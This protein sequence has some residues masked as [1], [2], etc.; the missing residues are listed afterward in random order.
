MVLAKSLRSSAGMPRKKPIR[1]TW[2]SWRPMSALSGSRRIAV[3]F[4][5]AVSSI[6]TPPS[7]DAMTVI[8]FVARSRMSP[9]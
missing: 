8:A 7:A 5:F 2:C 1:R 3:G 9:R 6:S 4:V